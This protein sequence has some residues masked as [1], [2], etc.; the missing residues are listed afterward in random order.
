M[1]TEMD[2]IVADYNILKIQK[3]KL[4]F[5]YGGDLEQTLI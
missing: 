2:T 3:V 1:T 5:F 4:N